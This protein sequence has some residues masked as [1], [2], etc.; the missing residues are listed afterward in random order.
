MKYK[1]YDI[2]L[3][4]LNPTQGSEQKGTRPCILLQNNI[5]NSSG[6]QTITIAP[7]STKKKEYP[8]SLNISASKT[9]N[10]QADSRIELSQ[11]RTI[12]IL[13]IIHFIGKLDD[14]YRK[15]LQEKIILFFDI[16]DEF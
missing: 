10:L 16:Y 2:L 13:R 3:I 1:K 8:S 5:A 11:I 7:L 15:E 6:L 4:H 9:N 14:Q 12:D